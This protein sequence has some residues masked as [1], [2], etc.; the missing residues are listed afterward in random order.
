MGSALATVPAR[1]A[2]PRSVT[3]SQ[4]SLSAATDPLQLKASVS[5]AHA[6]FA[7]SEFCLDQ[8]GARAQ[9]FMDAIDGCRDVAALQKVLNLITAGVQERHRE[10]LP[11]L[12]DC[13]REINE[14]AD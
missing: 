7:L 12:I 10:R 13:A 3:L 14:T 5:L 8:F 9:Q 4:P 1:A 11:K 2:A 6:R